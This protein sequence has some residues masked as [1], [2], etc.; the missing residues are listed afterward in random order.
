[1]VEFLTQVPTTISRFMDEFETRGRSY[2]LSSPR[3]HYE[4]ESDLNSWYASTRFTSNIRRI[5]RS[6]LEKCINTLVKAGVINEV[7]LRKWEHINNRKMTEEIC[8][9]DFVDGC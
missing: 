4:S 2:I 7:K 9:A 6:M 1:M 3:F 5:E 8:H